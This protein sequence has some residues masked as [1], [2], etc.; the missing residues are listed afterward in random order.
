MEEEVWGEDNTGLGKQ[1]L[2]VWG[3]GCVVLVLGEG[4]GAGRER[5][6]SLF[7]DN[8]VLWSCKVLNVTTQCRNFYLDTSKSPCLQLLCFHLGGPSC[9]MCNL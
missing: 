7:Q 5:L 6:L 1:V 2:W 8:H 3:R 9:I 4:E